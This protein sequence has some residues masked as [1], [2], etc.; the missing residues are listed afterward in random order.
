MMRRWVISGAVVLLALWCVCWLWFRSATAQ[1]ATVYTFS[2]HVDSSYSVAGPPTV[3]AAFITRV[4]V[5]YRSPTAGDGQALYDLGVKYGIDPVYALAFFWHESGFGTAGEAT[6]TRSLGNERCI[7]DRPCIDRNR[8]GFA[9]MQSWEDGFD[10]WYRLILYG[11]VQGQV[12]L[13]IVGHDCTTVDQIVPVYA[14]GGDGNDVAAYI[15]AVKHAV[16]TWWRG[17]V[18]V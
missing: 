13:P 10:H 2:L 5:A 18:W 8:G 16:T 14:P 1:D 7:P 12:T 9:L 6:V 4:L 15:A 11:Y 3:S 17:Q